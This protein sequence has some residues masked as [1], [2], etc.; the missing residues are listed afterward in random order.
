[1][2][3]LSKT[4]ADLDE[5]TGAAE[6]IIQLDP[7]Y[8]AAYS[9]GQLSYDTIH[10]TI[11]ADTGYTNVRVQIGQ[12]MHVPFYNDSGA[13]II[14]GRVINGQGIDATSNTIKGKPADASHPATSSVILGLATH[15]VGIGEV[16]LATSSGNVNDIDTSGL[17]E[18]G[19]VYL[20][21]EAGG[22]LTND[23]PTFPAKIT[24]IGTNVHIGTTDGIMI[25][26]L[27]PFTRGTASKS[28]SFT[29]NGIAGGS[30][31]VAGFYEADAGDMNLS[32]GTLT[33]DFGTANIAY[34]AHA[35][36]V[37]G[38][39]TTDA[40]TVE[41]WVDG[42]SIID[43][44]TVTT[45]D[46]ERISLDITT[47]SVDAYLE[48]SK[49]WLG[50]V[51]Y[52]LNP[53]GATTFTADF[54]VGIC[55]YEDFFNR[56]ITITSLEVVGL[57]SANPTD[58]SFNV[59]LLHHKAIG[60]TYHAT[61]FIPGDGAICDWATDMAPY[62]NITNGEYFAYK[63]TNLDTFIEGSAQEGLMIRVTTSQ[64]NSVQSM[65]I[66]ANGV[67]EELIY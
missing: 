37:A 28:Y 15:N 7:V 29:S 67:I 33:G 58:T 66:H 4:I 17:A 24:I 31:Y 39:G 60:W 5:Q 55:K 13:E 34:A 64:S 27:D 38:G 61:A 10:K 32:N 45:S 16:G 30:Y 56:D 1:M 3:K 22:K 11:V 21:A 19:I 12:E 44:G 49:K 52:R 25:V 51:T 63:R 42:D 6:Q 40:G 23:R 53:V 26:K 65:D 36:A 41:L 54:N 18:S 2:Q 62:D 47:E 48:T 50:I 46:S 9:A 59:E 57:S 43:D 8:A 20:S 14:N 35:F